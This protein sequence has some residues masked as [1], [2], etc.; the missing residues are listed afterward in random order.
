MGLAA[1]NARRRKDA[2]AAKTEQAKPEP[3]EQKKPAPKPK[4]AKTED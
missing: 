1:H 2:K 3:V 4:A